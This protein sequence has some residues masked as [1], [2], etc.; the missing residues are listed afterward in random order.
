MKNKIQYLIIIFAL[1]VQLNAQSY[2]G[3]IGKG[4][5]WVDLTIS[6]S[7]GSV[8]GSYFY[9]KH[10]NEIKLSGTIKDSTISL[11]EKVENKR[12]TGY[13]QCTLSGNSISGT[14]KKDESSSA[15]QVVL[16]KTNP[17]YKKY[18]KTPKPEELLLSDGST[19]AK[20]LK[21]SI[22]VNGNSTGEK[23]VLVTTF[24]QK[25]ILSTNHG[26]STMGAYPSDGTTYN[27]FNLI[28][29][30]EIVLWDEIDKDKKASFN[31][32]LCQKIQPELTNS[33]KNNADSEW[34]NALGAVDDSGNTVPIDKY[35]IIKDVYKW[36]DYYIDNKYLHFVI[37][38][39]F[40]FPH[41]IQE[42]DLS[43]DI[44]VP[45]AELDNYLK[46]ESILKRLKGT[47]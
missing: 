38:G 32:Y 30:K 39:Y 36:N 34:V 33:R 28:I 42:M 8:A 12:I 43:F 40:D 47:E 6:N 46:N 1:C 24:D 9:K 7:D 15:I 5:V 17:L 13:L 35:F 23:P 45:F 14:W 2:E 16:Y 25:N 27:T 44:P 21:E 4:S 19:L 22:S 41:V 26:W 18:A 20:N 10:D 11:T 31:T 29:K 3:Y 37:S